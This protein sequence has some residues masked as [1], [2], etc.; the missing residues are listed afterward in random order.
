MPPGPMPKRSDE[1]Q[2]RNNDGIPVDKIDLGG[3]VEIPHAFFF[4]PLINDLWLSLRSSANVR[5]FEP[6][7]WAYAKL[8][9]TLLERE[10][11]TDPENMKVPGAMLMKTFDD[12]LSKML[13]TEKDRR[14][15][16]IEVERGSKKEEG[17]VLSASKRFEE[18]FNQQRQA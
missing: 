9:L 8:T 5:F 17:K 12:M 10:V 4:N 6:T 14:T 7:D 16:R 15:L 1:R 2:R 11:G 13:L 18:R 3:E